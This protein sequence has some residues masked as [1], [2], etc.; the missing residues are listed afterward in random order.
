[1]FVSNTA[2]LNG[3]A[4]Y[5]VTGQLDLLHITVA[6]PYA[7]SQTAL[8][9]L[10]AT[11]HITNTIIADYEIGINAGGPTTE[12]YN[13]YYGN[14]TNTLGVTTG[15]HSLIDDPHFIDTHQDD[16]HL[17]W[18]SPA[19]DRGVDMGVSTDLDGA[20]RPEGSGVDIGTYEFQEPLH[21]IFILLMSSAP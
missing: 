21:K 16:Y 5:V 4:L 2:A 9:S 15:P 11:L 8:L 1:M 3:A 19:I 20:P 17:R 14:I 7:N 10:A 12:D 6:S 18:D 13:L